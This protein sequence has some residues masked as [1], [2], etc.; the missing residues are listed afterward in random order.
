MRLLRTGHTRIKGLRDVGRGVVV[1]PRHHRNIR[2]LNLRLLYRVLAHAVGDIHVVV[3]RIA[4]IRAH[5]RGEVRDVLGVVHI[6]HSHSRLHLLPRRVQGEQGQGRSIRRLLRAQLLVDLLQILQISL[7]SIEF[8]LNF[9]IRLAKPHAIVQ[10]AF[11]PTLGLIE[12]GLRLVEQASARNVVVVSVLAPVQGEPVRLVPRRHVDPVQVAVLQRIALDA[13]L[14]LLI[15]QGSP[16]RAHLRR[17]P[18]LVRVVRQARGDRCPALSS[19]ECA[20]RQS[21]Q[22]SSEL[23]V[24]LVGDAQSISNAFHHLLVLRPKHLT[25]GIA[26]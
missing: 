21:S 7:S 12:L 22:P 1:Q 15:S 6:P 11:I 23:R 8:C 24:H 9:C 14:A 20:H 25:L 18:R 13:R 5:A 4:H 26:E 17:G 2:P 16:P 19:G 10:F 3:Q